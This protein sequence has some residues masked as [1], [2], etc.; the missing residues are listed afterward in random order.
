MNGQVRPIGTY[1]E[2]DI[3]AMFRLMTAFYDNVEEAVFRRDFAD[4][5]Y[6]LALRNDDGEIVGFTTQKIMTIDV[7]GEPVHGIFSGDTIIHKD[8]WGETELFRVFSEFWFQY[9]E[10]FDEF[11]WFLICKGYK[12][13]RILPLFWRECYPNYRFETPARVKSI[14]DAYASAL[15]PDEYNPVTGVIE[16]KHTKDK[17]RAGVADID[18][19]ALRSR[20][21]SFFCKAN[22]G[23]INGNDIACLAKFDRSLLNPRMLK[24]MFG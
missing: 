23:H 17:L 6:C 18:D 1:T 14:I 5:D 22:P 20:D 24:V 19:H 8:Y 13:Y 9:A 15:Y 4:K 21:T 10:Q 12:T 3:Q 16:Y 2:A 11:W 7:G